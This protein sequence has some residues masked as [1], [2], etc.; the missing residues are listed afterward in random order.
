MHGI[1][2]KYFSDGLKCLLQPH[3]AHLPAHLD[4]DSHPQ[5]LGDGAFEHLVAQHALIHLINGA[6]HERHCAVGRMS[7]G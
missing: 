6:F 3:G 7:Q 4:L 5:I 1:P 2:F